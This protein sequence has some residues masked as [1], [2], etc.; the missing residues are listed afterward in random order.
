MASLATTT[1]LGTISELW[2]FPVKSM[3][4]ETVESA[5]FDADGMA[6]DRRYAV[7]D[8]DTGKIASAKRPGRWGVLL[9]CRATTDAGGVVTV[10]LPDGTCLPAGSARLDEAIATL[11][12]RRVRV[13]HV[14]DV[15]PGSTSVYEADYPDNEHLRL[16]GRL[17][18]PAAMV[19][20]AASFVDLSAVHVITDATLAAVAEASGSPSVTSARFRANVVVTTGRAAGFVE[21]DWE[22]SRVGLGPNVVLRG[23]GRAPRC[24]MTSVEQ[25]GLDRD[26]RV[27]LAIARDHRVEVPGKGPLPCAGVLGEVWAGGTVEVGDDISLMHKHQTTKASEGA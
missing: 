7:R 20:D 9:R 8:L 14:D 21:D 26:D 5:S 2:R 6:G 16:R 12:G 11:T 18:F 19:T 10:R 22:G 27:F 13:E 1:T 15:E 17:E 4:G 3:G 25:P 24:I 23:L